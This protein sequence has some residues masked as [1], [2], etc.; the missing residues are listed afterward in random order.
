[1]LGGPQASVVDIATLQ[2]FPFIDLIL[3]GEADASF[4]ILLE[5]LQRPTP[6]FDQVPGL[7]HKNGHRVV[8]NKDAALVADLDKL[9]LPAFD[10]DGDLSETQS[11]PLEIG[12]G[13]PF[14]CTFCS[15]ND[16]FRRRFRLKSPATIIDQ[17]R[18]LSRTHGH[19]LFDLT[20]DL[21]TVDRKKVE[22]FCYALIDSG[23]RFRWSCSAR[24]D[25]IDEPLV[26]L[27]KKAGCSGLFYGIESGSP[28]M[29]KIIAKNLDLEHARQMVRAA[30]QH[31]IETTVS[32]IMGYPEE[33][34]DD[35]ELSFEFFLESLASKRATPQLNLLAPLAG[36]PICR[37]YFDQL[38]LHDLCSE[39]SRQG[40]LEDPVERLLI[41]A[42]VDIFPNFYLL[43]TQFLD[44][45][46]LLELS[47][48]FEMAQ[49]R[50]RWLLLALHRALPRDLVFQL[51]LDWVEQRRELHPEV[52][53]RELRHYYA[54]MQFRWEFVDLVRAR[55]TIWGDSAIEALCDC[56]QFAKSCDAAD[57]DEPE[58]DD[59][60]DDAASY[61]RRCRNVHV[62][63][64]NWDMSAILRMLQ[65]GKS[66]EDLRGRNAYITR[67]GRENNWSLI[68][69]PRP[70][71]DL[72]E[73]C[74]GSK[75]LEQIT[76]RF[77][78][79]HGNWQGFDAALICQTVVND[80]L[81]QGLLR[82]DRRISREDAIH[83]GGHSNL[84]YISRSVEASA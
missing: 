77:R 66:E 6:R 34:R 15:T 23:E 36:T 32:Q 29:Q 68:K 63:E 28:R 43:P 17:M 26:G 14:A 5:E 18:F 78:S 69:V 10:L 54:K 24:T 51:V 49:Q 84:E 37:E 62:F 72:V 50:L 76:S 22:E 65:Q 83:A 16:F 75:T 21:F 4:P 40:L 80:Y 9:P 53:V 3:R 19:N 25:C 46:T 47:V 79:T 31:G 81:Q 33:T 82:M 35:L 64:V 20:H 67:A 2:A 55:N 45:P 59:D 30:E 60:G 48:F 27:M 56:E 44:G 12:R 39:V 42:H 13:C 57:S 73:W 58:S 7:T 11:I 8:R 71:A 61:P 1:V 38:E 74:D 52:S 70:V 41:A